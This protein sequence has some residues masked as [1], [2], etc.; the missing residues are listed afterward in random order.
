MAVLRLQKGM[1]IITW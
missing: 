1:R